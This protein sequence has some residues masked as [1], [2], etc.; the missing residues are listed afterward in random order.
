VQKRYERL[1]ELSTVWQETNKIAARRRR[2]KPVPEA[3]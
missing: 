1:T 2:P 3:A